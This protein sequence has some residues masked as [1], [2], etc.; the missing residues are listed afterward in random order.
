MPARSDYRV[1]QL[2]LRCLGQEET[3]T[4]ASASLFLSTAR[5]GDV[6]GD[7]KLTVSD[8]EAQ[9]NKLKDIPAGT[10][11]KPRTQLGSADLN[12]TGRITV[13][14]IQLAVDALKS[15]RYPFRDLTPC[16]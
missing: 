15:F 12:P 5:W 3:C 8:V 14:E 16:P 11:G 6:D 7:A 2:D 13:V 9:V 4:T 10:L 1:R